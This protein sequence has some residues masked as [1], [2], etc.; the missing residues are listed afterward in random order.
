MI[1]AAFL[2]RDGVLNEDIGYLCQPED[3]HW[4]PGALEA[5]ALLQQAGYVVFV[6][7]NQSGVA[8][9]YYTEAVVRQLHDWMGR[10]IARAGGCVKQFYY[11]PYLAGAAVKEYD[12]VSELRKPAPGMVLQAARDYDVDLS[13][14]FL[15][16]DKETDM[17]CAKAAGVK[18]YLFTEGRL[19]TFVRFI[20]KE[21]M[22]HE[23]I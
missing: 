22:G 16:G 3:V 4:M 5:L 20:L 19:D 13:C 12:R 21:G 11:C 23:G 14:S 7:T 6:V 8:R 9:G 2:D 10:E 18:G 15:I 17:A 1:R